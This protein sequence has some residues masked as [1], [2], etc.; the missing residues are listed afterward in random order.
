MTAPLTRLTDEEELF[1]S[2]IAKFAE[3]H[4]RPH[5]EKMDEAEKIEPSILDGLFEMGL[6]A[7]EIPEKYHGSGGSFFQAIVAI[8][9]IAK[10]DPSISILCDVQN[11]LVNNIF[12]NYGS[13]K[14]KKTY[15]PRLATKEVGCYC[16]TEADSGSDAFAL[17]S[18][19]YD[20]GSHWRINGKKVFIT[21][22]G[23]ANIF[24]VFANV[25]P[26]MGYK[27]ITCFLVEGNMPGCSLGKK[28]SKMGIRAS[29]TCE[30]LFEDVK[31]PKENVIGEVGKGYKIAIDTLNE[32]RIGVGAQM[33]GLAEGAHQAALKYAS[34]R[35][36]FGKELN[37]FQAIQF[38]LAELAVEIETAKL[39]TYNA[40]KL[41]DAGL[42]FVK[43]AAI[44]KYHTS[45]VAEHVASKSIDIFGGYG[46]IK[47]FPAEKYY[48]DAKIGQLYEGTSNMQLNTIFR[49]LAENE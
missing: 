27:G 16:L 44:A 39:V 42:P 34:E 40:A 20:E 32:G 1:R 41:K 7:I 43:E 35:K 15:F 6:M 12:L 25:N 45:Q 46:F 9:E 30:V 5:V 18:R 49:T 8:E 22:A 2:E 3:S 38:Q 24:L 10:V 23:E 37:E 26:D 21:N 48:R 29:S 19:A 17:K 11:T 33:L 31:V 14:Q 4:I 36:Q 28:E 13:E 47:E